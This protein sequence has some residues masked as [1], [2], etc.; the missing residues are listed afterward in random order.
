MS[1][2]DLSEL[3]EQFG[4]KLEEILEENEMLRTRLEE[5]DQELN[6]Y[7]IISHDNLTHLETLKTKHSRE[8]E[9]MKNDLRHTEHKC[10]DKITGQIREQERYDIEI[11]QLS[12]EV[13]ILREQIRG[14]LIQNIQINRRKDEL[15]LAMSSEKSESNRLHKEFKRV[16]EKLTEL[17]S[18]KENMDKFYQNL[19]DII[20]E[21]RQVI[22]SLEKKT[23]CKDKKIQELKNALKLE[24]QKNLKKKIQDNFEA[25]EMNNNNYYNY[26]REDRSNTPSC[27]KENNY[28]DIIRLL[29]KDIQELTQSLRAANEALHNYEFIKVEWDKERERRRSNKS[30]QTNPPISDP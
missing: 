6:Q 9:K 12:D 18:M 19:K 1:I 4:R 16:Q 15:E 7:L 29:E 21:Q 5:K 17:Y 20:I 8:I 2:E 30:T 23:E 11:N 14:Q 10:A 22:D 26:E 3:T 28:S 25:S 13:S 27:K 24:V